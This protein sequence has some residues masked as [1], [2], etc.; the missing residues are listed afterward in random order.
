MA[1]DPLVVYLTNPR[2]LRRREFNA[3]ARRISDEVAGGRTFCCCVSTDEHLQ[4]LNR[5]FRATD[6]PTDV[7]SFPAA[8]PGGAMGDLAISADRA[9]EQ[10]QA[11]GHEPGVE[12]G[13]LLLHGVLH[14]MG[15]DHEG[16][17]G[18]M[19]RIETRWRRDLGLPS[20]L[21]ER[22]ARR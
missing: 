8:G 5:D 2:W 20:G 14:L 4:Q 6:R 3:F 9:R 15:Y 7:L 10:A 18:R 11:H 1:S 19:R 22:T 17:R 13:I 21:I 12:L 16:D